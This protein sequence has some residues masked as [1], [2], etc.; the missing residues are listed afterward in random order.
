MDSTTA[1]NGKKNSILGNKYIKHRYVLSYTYYSLNIPKL[2]HS[3]R[4]H[5]PLVWP[6]L[7]CTGQD[8][9]CFKMHYFSLQVTEYYIK[10]IFILLAVGISLRNNANRKLDI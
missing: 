6:H 8:Q 3:T 1:Y 9:T 10:A 4:L 7:L 2:P 5:R